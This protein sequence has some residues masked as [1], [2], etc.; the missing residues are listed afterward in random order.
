MTTYYHL[1]WVYNK[2]KPKIINDKPLLNYLEK[3]KKF[4]AKLIYLIIIYNLIESKNVVFLKFHKLD[5]ISFLKF[6]SKLYKNITIEFKIK[7][8]KLMFML[9]QIILNLLHITTI[10]YAQ[11]IS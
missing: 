3:N 1:L 4:I 8:N 6:F 2:N 5:W 10:H 9:L 7:I 11:K